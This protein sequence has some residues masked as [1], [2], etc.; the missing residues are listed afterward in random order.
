MK[1]LKVGL[2]L[3]ILFS[4]ISFGASHAQSRRQMPKAERKV[5]KS[6]R[7]LYVK[8]KKAYNFYAYV[9]PPKY[10]YKSVAEYEGLVRVGKNN[11]PYRERNINRRLF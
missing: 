11:Q 5:R 7:K 4:F 10:K 2:A 6:C 8:R 3:V 1:T 9:K